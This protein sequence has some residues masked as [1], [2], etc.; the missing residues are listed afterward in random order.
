MS[1]RVLS[2]VAALFVALLPYSAAAPDT[3]SIAGVVRDSSGGIV[4]GASVRVINEETNAAT[5][6]VTDGTG[7]YNATALPP[8]P[9]RVEASLDGFDTAVRR[10]PLAAGQAGT[11]D[12]V[13]NP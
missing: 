9:Y 13:L 12:V 3:A 6:L 11:L 8:G 5:E 2:F 10:L 7:S 1:R 4:P